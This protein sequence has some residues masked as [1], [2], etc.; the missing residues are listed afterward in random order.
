[1]SMNKFDQFFKTNVKFKINVID[2]YNR[3]KLIICEHL[4]YSKDKY[5]YQFP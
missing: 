5:Q 1:M 2:I 3:I 4:R